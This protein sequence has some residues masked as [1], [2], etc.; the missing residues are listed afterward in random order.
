MATEAYF[1][2]YSSAIPVFKKI[3]VV[4]GGGGDGTF[5][6]YN[7]SIVFTRLEEL[8]LLNAE[9]LTVLGRGE[10]AIQKL[11]AIRS[12]RGIAGL[13]YTPNLDLLKEIF[14]ERRRELLGEGW[15]WF[16]LVRY[17]KLKRDNAAFNTL[18]DREGIYWPIAQDVLNRNPNIQQNSYWK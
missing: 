7:S 13:N 5:A 14:A 2:N 8:T 10:E 3:R 12:N 15:R 18:I 9:A 17:N 11:N 16:D 6:K 4:D 1:E